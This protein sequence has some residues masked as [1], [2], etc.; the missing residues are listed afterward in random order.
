MSKP[1]IL[2][3]G[4]DYHNY[5]RGV[6][7][8]EIFK[9]NQDYL[10]FIQLINRFK[11]ISID[12]SCFV[13]MPNH[14]H[15]LIKNM[16]ENGI[17][18]FMQNVLSNYTKYFNKK[19]KRT[20]ALFE[21]RFK[22]KHVNTDEYLNHIKNYIWCNPI[23]LIRKDYKSIDLFLGKIKLNKKEITFLN[24][25]QYKYFKDEYVPKQDY[26]NPSINIVDF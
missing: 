19:Y 16:L 21:S 7:K 10:F 25:Y 13:L 12:I 14:F 6:E 9:D 23:K 2:Y 4:E 24:K 3:T 11:T 1:R 22:S 17:S 26:L 18:K 5:S 15:F 8:K 20:G